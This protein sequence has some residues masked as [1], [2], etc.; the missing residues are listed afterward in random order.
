VRGTCLQ[1]SE[2][3]PT[4]QDSDFVT[5]AF[6]VLVDATIRTGMR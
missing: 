6:E 4:R 5:L 3:D 1:A 2:D